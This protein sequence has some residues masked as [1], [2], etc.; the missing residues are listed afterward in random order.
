MTVRRSKEGSLELVGPCD[1]EDAE[2]GQKKIGGGGEEKADAQGRV[3]D[4]RR[5]VEPHHLPRPGL[6]V[7]RSPL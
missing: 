1:V 4:G 7:R 5:V 3:K 2:E 6:T